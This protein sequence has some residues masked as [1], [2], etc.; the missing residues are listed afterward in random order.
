MVNYAGGKSEAIE[1]LKILQGQVKKYYDR[2]WASEATA[3]GQQ[4]A[5]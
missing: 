1:E 3:P 5:D 2:V 4:P